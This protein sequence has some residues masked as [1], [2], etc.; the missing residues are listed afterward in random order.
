LLLF[1][2][3]VVVLFLLD[4]IEAVDDVDGPR[5]LDAFGE[6]SDEPEKQKQTNLKTKQNNLKIKT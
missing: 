1:L 2:F 4:L 3:V 6:L 5:V